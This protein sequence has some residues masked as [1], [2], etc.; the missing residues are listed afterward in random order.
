VRLGVSEEREENAAMS[1]GGEAAKEC[2]SDGGR[3]DGG[4]TG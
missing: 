2:A 4:W 1:R 3:R